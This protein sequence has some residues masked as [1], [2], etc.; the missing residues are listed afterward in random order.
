VTN[1]SCLLPALV[2]VCVL[3]ACPGRATAYIGGPPT[4]LGHIAGWSDYIVLARVDSVDRD[5]GIIAYR[6]VRDIKGSWPTEVIRHVFP[7][8]PADS[9]NAA[10]VD[11][12]ERAYIFQWA[13]KGKTAVL[14]SVK[15]QAMSY[16]YVDQCWYCTLAA[17][18]EK[19]SWALWHA[20]SIAPKS[21]STFCCGKPSA[22]ATALDDI[23]AG[24][25]AVVPV[26][27]E[28]TKE[29][30]RQGKARI[31]EVRASLKILDFDPKREAPLADPPFDA[32]K[33]DDKKPEP[34]DKKPEPGEK[35]PDTG[36]KKPEPGT[37]DPGAKKADDREP[38]LA[39]TVKAVSADGKSFTML[40]PPNE[41]RPEPT[42]VDIQLYERTRIINGKLAVGQTVSVWLGKSETPLAA[43]IEIGKPS[44]KPDK[45]APEDKGKK[46]SPE[47]KGKQPAPEDKS[48]KPVPEAPEKK[49]VEKKAD[50]KKPDLVGVIKVISADGKSL[51]L[52]QLPT[53]KLPEPTAVVI[54]ISEDTKVVPGKDGGKL[55]VGQTVSVWLGKGDAKVAVKI[56]VGKPLEKPDNPEKKPTPDGKGKKPD[57]E[58]PEKKPEAPSKP[59][60]PAKPP[61]DPVPTA[62]IIDTEVD[63]QLAAE[64][65]PASPQADDAEFLRR[66]TLDLTGRIPTYQQTVAF[67]DSKDPDKRR[68][69]VD[70]LLESPAYSEHFA[71]VW[72][73]L[74]VGRGPVVG[75]KGGG[76]GNDPFRSWLAE[77][78]ND[79]RGWNALVT[80]LLTAEGNPRDNPATT[81]LLVNGENNQPQPNR[82]TGAAAGLFWGVNLRCA[83]CHNHPFARWNQ[84]D[85]WGTAA[86]FGKL[87]NGGGK[88]GPQ[89]LTEAVGDAG[90]VKGKGQAARP[91]LRGT[92]I[93]IPAGTGKVSGQAIKARFL[94]GDE[95]ALDEKEPFRPR[96]AAWATAADNPYFARAAVNRMWAHF[97]GRGLVNPLDG[98]DETNPPSHPDLLDKLAREFAS[99]G[100]DLKH[101]A[102]CITASK[103]YQRGHCPV[104]GNE[105]DTAGF[106]HMAVKALTPEVLFDSLAIATTGRPERPEAR[107]PFVRLFRVDDEA[108]PT[109]YIQGIPQMLRLMN[110]PVSGSFK[111][112]RGASV[113]DQLASSR[114]SH[115]EAVTTLYLTALSRRPTADEVKLME[116]Y[117][118]K[119]KDNREGYRGVLWIL[120]NS[121]EFALNH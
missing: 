82:V 90:L 106:S 87:Q 8:K 62:A 118:S 93:V 2:F 65:I 57:P 21:L 53:V 89:N 33:T 111:G 61:R 54:Q 47:D 102:R 94:G 19:D 63:K 37:Q 56:Q 20:F 12:K 24:K 83:E 51:T 107:E 85:F 58:T 74:I 22:L 101:L 78:F 95:P 5:K 55:A 81:F 86:F 50:E 88:G 27:S 99:S 23:L 66:V 16:A 120:L 34:A 110:A 105:S 108:S 115:A 14:F 4:T 75:G 35:Q 7:P 46:P 44:D 40:R 119:R 67:L 112:G 29:D 103:T 39:G 38:D 76:N 3:A 96:F 52:K 31:K 32:R 42:P 116:G 97:F 41:K 113:V 45:A 84:S 18:R 77:Q 64:K 28:G 59:K 17:H 68:K 60:E 98:F 69:L 100:F 117:L 10:P 70:E 48:K 91:A 43:I 25:E 79:N 30:L 104:P 71:T 49:P 72:R 114:T 109:E 92:A 73:N 11:E 9:K 80:D 15:A 121:S 13:E 6:K 36:K 26:V 1:R